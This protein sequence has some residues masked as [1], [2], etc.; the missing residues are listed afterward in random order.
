MYSEDNDNSWA[1]P[2]S[3]AEEDSRDSFDSDGNEI[4]GWP[5]PTY[6]K[7]SFHDGVPEDY[8]PSSAFASLGEASVQEVIQQTVF[9]HNSRSLQK[10]QQAARLRITRQPEE[11]HR[12]RYLSEGSRGAIKDRSGT[13]HC[14]IQVR[15][16]SRH[17]II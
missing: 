16:S 3:D 2:A 9:L 4:D 8:Q 17:V 7:Q 11:Q 15:S 5:K 6:H 1:P 13:S 12:A 14:T 10:V